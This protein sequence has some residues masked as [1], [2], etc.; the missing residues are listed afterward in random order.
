MIPDLTPVSRA[1]SPEYT[2]ENGVLLR[3]EAL[4]ARLRDLGDDTFV[5]L[6]PGEIETVALRIL[7]RYARRTPVQGL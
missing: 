2:H 6:R 7:V 5:A 3:Y 1:T 4:L